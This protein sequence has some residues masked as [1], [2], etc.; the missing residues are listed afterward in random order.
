[1]GATSYTFV[2]DGIESALKQAREAAGDKDVS[3]GGGARIIQQ[4]LAGGLVDVLQVHLSP[5]LVG[6]GTRLFE[7]LGDTMPKLEQERVRESP[8]ATHIRYRV[9]RP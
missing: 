8:N 6:G 2:T 9:V 7:N 3:I 1:V 4:F 5:V